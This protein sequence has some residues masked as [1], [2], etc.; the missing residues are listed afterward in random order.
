MSKKGF[1]LL[2]TAIKDLFIKSIDTP[3]DFIIRFNVHPNFF[4]ILGLI[5]SAIGAV[6]YAMGNL[7]GGGAGILISGICDTFDGKIARKSGRSSK[8]GALFDSS[9]D[10]YAEFMMF[11]GIMAYL[12]KFN[13]PLYTV[14]TV[15]AFLALNGSILVSYVRARAEGLG[16][17]CKVGMMQRAE[18]I[19]LIGFSSMVH[20]YALIGAVWIVAIFA[21]ITAIQRMV[22]VWRT[23][24]EELQRKRLDE[25]LEEI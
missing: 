4:T 16:Y 14:T 11:L 22:H 7:I 15:V 19:V 5:A 3:V 9:L 21:N 25:S 12:I 17:D 24:R 20:E 10:R 1:T 6:F 23:E 18:R 2:P 13:D 8:F